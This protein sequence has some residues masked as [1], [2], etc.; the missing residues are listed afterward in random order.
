MNRDSFRSVCLL[1]YMF[2]FSWKVI[3]LEY[4]LTCLSSACEMFIVKS[5]DL[6]NLKCNAKMVWTDYLVLIRRILF[7][8]GQVQNPRITGAFRFFH[9]L[10]VYLK[11]TN[12]HTNQTKQRSRP[13]G[14]I[15][16]WKTHKKPSRRWPKWKFLKD[17]QNKLFDP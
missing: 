7:F 8:Y 4:I 17:D 14:S 6:L 9:N 15:I 13:S 12:N 2:N 11:G 5:N 3:C 16:E 1:I 10:S